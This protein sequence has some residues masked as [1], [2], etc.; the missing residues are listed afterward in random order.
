QEIT[1]AAYKI[2]MYLFL[3]FALTVAGVAVAIIRRI[4]KIQKDKR[5]QEL[6]NMRNTIAGDLHDDV[7]STLSSIQI[8]S[9]LALKQCNG[10]EQLAQSVSRI[11]ELSDKVSDGIRE[12][13]WSV[14]PAHDRLP[15]VTAQLRKMAADVLGVNDIAFK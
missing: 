11:S 3:I 1:I 6:E 13:V 15:S 7:G 5:H 8:I 14:N 12:I 4:R 2:R 10:N 9:N